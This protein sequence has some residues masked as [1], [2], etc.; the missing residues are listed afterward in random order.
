[1]DKKPEKAQNPAEVKRHLEALA[2]ASIDVD[3]EQLR[4]F[5][6]PVGAFDYDDG[7][8]A[9]RTFIFPTLSCN[10]ATLLDATGV[11]ATA[12]G[13]SQTFLLSNF[14]CLPPL[15]SFSEPVSILA[16]ARSASP[17]F[18]TTTH[19]MVVDPNNPQSFNDV[20]IT[21]YAWDAKGAPAAG[22]AVD[23]RC[24][25]VSIPIIG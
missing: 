18:V 2:G 15:R 14:V 16:T 7:S 22:V 21:V 1:M 25:V 13:G 4:F 11:S 10:N 6:F 9:W 12:A 20:E 24:R 23:W 17:F 19:T 5:R 3:P 8:S